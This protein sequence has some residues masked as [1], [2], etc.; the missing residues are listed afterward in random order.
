MV[1]KGTFLSRTCF[2]SPLSDQTKLLWALRKRLILN[3]SLFADR[4][5]VCVWSCFSRKV[6]VMIVAT[7]QSDS[8]IRKRD[9]E[10]QYQS[11]VGF[12]QGLVKVAGLVAVV[13]P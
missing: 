7:N 5:S 3:T 11:S 1:F 10:L 12:V 13:G 9:R 2:F 4:G 6:T 8:N